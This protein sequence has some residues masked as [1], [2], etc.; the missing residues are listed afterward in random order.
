MFPIAT[1]SVVPLGSL[2]RSSIAVTPDGGTQSLALQDPDPL[3]GE[4]PSPPVALVTQS[5]V[6]EIAAPDGFHGAA[7]DPAGPSKRTDE[8]LEVAAA[9]A[10]EVAGLGSGADA[11]ES[12]ARNAVLTGRAGVAAARKSP[13][14]SVA[15]SREVVRVV[16]MPLR[17]HG[18]LGAMGVAGAGGTLLYGPPGTGKTS[19]VCRVAEECGAALLVV[20]GPE[21]MSQARRVALWLMRCSMTPTRLLFSFSTSSQPSPFLPPHLSPHCIFFLQLLSVS[22][23]VSG[24][25]RGR[26]PRRF[27]GG[28]VSLSEHP[29]HRRA[30][31]S[32]PRPRAWLRRALREGCGRFVRRDR[33]PR[34]VGGGKSGG[35]GRQQPPRLD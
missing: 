19:L 15:A 28:E 9:A 21:I 3:Q 7:H 26:R 1:P 5:T 13:L 31:L 33:R 34:R 25:L 4:A 35:G 29:L 27:R 10:R 17:E 18:R 2:Y 22:L 12:A 24:R 23:A 16:G 32:R 14:A 6:V 11:A 20:N 8:A 30:R